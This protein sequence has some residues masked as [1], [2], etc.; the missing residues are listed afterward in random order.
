MSEQALTYKDLGP[1]DQAL[2]DEAGGGNQ[3]VVS[4]RMVKA[5]NGNGNAAIMLSQLLFWSRQ[6]AGEDGWFYR[7]R[8]QMEKRCGAGMYHN[9]GE[10]WVDKFG[11]FAARLAV[12]GRR[13]R[14]PVA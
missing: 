8:K 10:S 6:K 11:R 3:T 9:R 14:R 4:A 1:R 5:L 13:L 12:P 7:T 2:I